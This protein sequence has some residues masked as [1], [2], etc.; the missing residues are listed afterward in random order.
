MIKAFYNINEMAA[1]LGMTVASI[2]G[3]LARKNFDAVPPPVY[4]GRRLAWPTETSD[5][6]IKNKIEKSLTKMENKQNT[7]HKKGRPTKA[8]TRQKK[9]GF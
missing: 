4:L 9:R 8:E 3:H 7:P 1:I 5:A 2:Y 6:W